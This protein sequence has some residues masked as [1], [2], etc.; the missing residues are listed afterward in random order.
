MITQPKQFSVEHSSIF[1]DVSVVAAYAHRSP[2]PPKTFDLLAGLIDRMSSPI[3]ILDAGCGTGQMTQGLLPHADRIDAVDI[4]AAMI[5]AGKQMAY[6]ADPRI[7]WI[8]GSIDEVAF[9]PPYAL[10]VAAAS[11]HWMPW[12]VTLPRFAQ[13]L[14]KDGYL[15]LVEVR[16]APNA[17]N[18][19]LTPILA[20]YSMN[21][22]FQ[23]YNMLTVA[24]ELQ[25][26]GLFRQLGVT[27]TASIAFRQS[28]TDWVEAFHATN[29]FSRDRMDIARAAE[30]DKHV[31]QIITKHCPNG[32]VEQQIGA[33]IV[34]GKPLAPVAV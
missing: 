22:D 10:I 29:G 27:E 9:N 34:F 14:S 21:Q 31:R 1:Q 7:H 24:A 8:V 3:R 11:L 23:P 6:G 20:Q 30:F 25:Q 33:R 15:A 4:S 2:Y 28:I 17:W 12:A 5:A 16:S 32:M 13:V 18:D 26:Q 19:A